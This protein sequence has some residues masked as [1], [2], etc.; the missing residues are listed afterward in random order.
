M[1]LNI[2]LFIVLKTGQGGEIPALRA[3]DLMK[4]VAPDFLFDIKR[5]RFFNENVKEI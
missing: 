4:I 2:S 3:D 5:I 1:V